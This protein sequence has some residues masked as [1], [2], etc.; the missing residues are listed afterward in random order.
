MH[1]EAYKL[2]YVKTMEKLGVSADW[3]AGPLEKALGALRSAP[4]REGTAIPP[5]YK[6]IALEDLLKN[7]PELNERTPLAQKYLAPMYRPMTLEEINKPLPV[8]SRPV[9]FDSLHGKNSYS[10]VARLYGLV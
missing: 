1:T 10:Q 4:F 8:L 5:R 6:Q 3:I 7:L 2:G 9:S